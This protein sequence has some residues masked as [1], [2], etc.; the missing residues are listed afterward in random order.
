MIK[1][2]GLL[3]S[4][5]LFTVLSGCGDSEVV[6]EHVE[7]SRPVPMAVVTT[8]DKNSTLRFPGRVRAAQRADLAF[9]VPGQVIELPVE[10]G[11]LIEKGQLVARLDDANYKIQMRSSLAKYNKARTDYSRVDQLWKRSQA[12]A[13]AEVDKQRTAMDVA[14]ADYALTKKDF[15]DTR[16]IAPFSGVITKRYVENYSN[17]QDKEAI[18]SL[19]DLNNL[20]IVINVPE[21]I[22]RN[23]PKQSGQVL[24]YAIFAD[25]PELLLPVTLKSFSSDSDSQTQSYEVVLALD[26]GYE[27]T[28][29]PGMSVDV[30]PQQVVEGLTTGHVKVPLKAIYSSAD[31]ITGVWVFNPDTLRVSLQVVELGEVQG[32]D[33]VVIKGLVG[34]EQIVT[35]GVSQLREAMLVRAL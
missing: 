5:M 35:A 9:N 7:V 19:Q 8:S 17:V 6:E 31:N 24:G 1:R 15:D 2:I 4:A 30:L 34:G 29:L 10:E 22:V 11:Q 16:L 27:I 23:A 14:Q 26:P 3:A 25:Q 18:A 28:V 32:T 12:I 13:K 20:E 21:R 33:V